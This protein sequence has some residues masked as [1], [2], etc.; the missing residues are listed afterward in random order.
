MI[1][2]EI[3]GNRS[4]QEDLLDLL[5]K[6]QVGKYRTVITEVR[7][8]GSSGPRQ[9]DHIWPEENFIM[10]IFCELK[11]AKYIRKA[12]EELKDYFPDEGIKMFA[13]KVEK[14]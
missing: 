3:I 8:R 14:V 4:I 13:T 12:I 9:G 10:I 11:E 6:Y 7:G 2:V 5:D 1:R